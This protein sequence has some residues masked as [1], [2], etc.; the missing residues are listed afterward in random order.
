[1]DI[2]GLGEQLVEQLVDS[3]LA[4]SISDLYRL[5]E[6]ELLTLE[7][8]GPRK[9][10]NLLTA[11]R[12]SCSRPTWK[13]VFALGIPHV[14]ATSARALLGHFGS[15]AALSTASAAELESVDDVGTVVSESI[16]R[17]FGSVETQAMLAELDGLGLPINA[18]PGIPAPVTV[19]QPSPFVGTTWVITGTLSQPREAFV[20]RIIAA[21]GKVSSSISAATTFLLSGRKPAA[22]SP[23]PLA[24]AS[25][26]LMSGP[27]PPCWHHDA[28]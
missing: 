13:L 20:E 10:S 14:G 19:S 27:S 17:F 25:P 5:E 15:I 11:I 23:R 26:L 7:R 8:M 9:A 1:M 21:G 24:W 28:F 22:S 6:S 12:A 3:G 4:R 16:R 2:E 18:A